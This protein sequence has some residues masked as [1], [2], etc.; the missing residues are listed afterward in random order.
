MQNL[1]IEFGETTLIAACYYFYEKVGHGAYRVYF[2]KAKII[3]AEKMLNLSSMG[4]EEVMRE[5]DIRENS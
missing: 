4:E 2:D 3:N 5:L 1:W